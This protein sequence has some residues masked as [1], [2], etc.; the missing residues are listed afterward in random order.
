MIQ[1]KQKPQAPDLDQRTILIR[2]L[3]FDR[4]T[5]DFADKDPAAFDDLYRN[6]LV[7]SEPNKPKP[8]FMR[9]FS[10]GKH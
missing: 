1:Q 5:L 10:H 2:Q 6:I 3:S 9:L 4:R 7:R 8:F